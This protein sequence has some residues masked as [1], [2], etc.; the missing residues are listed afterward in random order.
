VL[1]NLVKHLMDPHPA[2]RVHAA[3]ALG[4]FQDRRLVPFL[5]ALLQEQDMELVKSAVRSLGKIGDPEAESELLLL[6][7]D[8]RP[9]LRLEAVVALGQ[10][11]VSD[12]VAGPSEN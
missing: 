4:N 10:L 9:A 1:K 6:L 12:P 8:S 5:T 3:E 11:Q 2:V 7:Q